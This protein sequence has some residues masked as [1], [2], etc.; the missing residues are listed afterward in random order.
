MKLYKHEIIMLVMQHVKHSSYS[1][2]WNLSNR[3]KNLVIIGQN[4][5][6]WLFYK[7]LGNSR[8]K[9]QSMFTLNLLSQ[10]Y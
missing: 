8:L 2:Y 1:F 6:H 10:K 7:T 3:E 9:Q 5:D 4:Q